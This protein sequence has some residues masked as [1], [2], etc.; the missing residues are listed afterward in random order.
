MIYVASIFN[1]IDITCYCCRNKSLHLGAI[2][3]LATYSHTCTLFYNYTFVYFIE[4]VKRDLYE[5]YYCDLQYKKNCIY[6]MQVVREK[7]LF[8]V[9]Q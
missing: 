2:P 7:Q 1:V 8:N 3:H 4:I 5:K 9:T 6:K